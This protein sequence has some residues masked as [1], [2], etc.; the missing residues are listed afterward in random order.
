MAPAPQAPPPAPDLSDLFDEVMPTNNGGAN[1]VRL[2]ELLRMQGSGQ[3]LGPQREAE[4]RSLLAA[5]RTSQPFSCPQCEAA[6]QPGAALCVACGLHLIQGHIMKA[7]KA[8]HHLIEQAERDLAEREA[9]QEPA[10]DGHGAGGVAAE[11]GL[12]VLIQILGG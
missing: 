10:H 5:C 4:K 3:S 12:E 8:K 6:T 2:L 9:R 11:I 1:R 7:A